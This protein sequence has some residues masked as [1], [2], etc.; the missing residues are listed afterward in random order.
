MQHKN[1]K[2]L[3]AGQPASDKAYLSLTDMAGQTL[4]HN[5]SKKQWALL[6][7]L[8]AKVLHSWEP[9]DENK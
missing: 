4:C 9:A 1:V 6:N 3:T 2:C 8:S 7:Y 5:L